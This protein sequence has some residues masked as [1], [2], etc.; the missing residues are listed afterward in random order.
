MR[1]KRKI[2][3]KLLVGVLIIIIVCTTNYLDYYKPFLIMI[4]SWIIVYR[5]VYHLEKH[6]NKEN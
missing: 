2:D 4:S 6:I 5:L 1:I 3:S